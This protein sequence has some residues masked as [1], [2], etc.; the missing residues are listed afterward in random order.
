MIR[1]LTLPI[2]VCA[3]L[4]VT[5]RAATFQDEPPQE[6]AFSEGE[7]YADLEREWHTAREA[8]IRE[9]QERKQA[10]DPFSAGPLAEFLPRFEK[11]AAEGDGRALLWVVGNGYGRTVGVAE[12]EKRSAQ[13]A[14]LVDLHADEDW[15]VEFA[16]AIVG[17]DAPAV[18]R[19]I[20]RS[21][22]PT[23]QDAN[24]FRFGMQSW[25]GANA[26]RFDEESGLHVPDEERNAK[27]RAEAKVIWKEYLKR[28]PEGR[29]AVTV[30]GFLFLIEHLQV[31]MVAP[32]FEGQTVDGKRIRLSDTR[33]KVTVI[34]FFGFW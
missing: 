19:L 11:L 34:D 28:F 10:Y 2:A 31:G 17:I 5:G 13:I 26:L 3:L 29:N 15:M 23:V 20:E 7:S 21:K 18:R 6:K 30:S 4:S 33:G 14:R 25:Y 12:G 1:T 24:L 9:R 16:E 8:W 27:A 32:D 22:N